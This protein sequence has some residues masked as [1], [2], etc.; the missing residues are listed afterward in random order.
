MR[1]PL[2]FLFSFLATLSAQAQSRSSVLAS[3][4]WLKIGVVQ[5]GLYRLDRA[6]LNRVAPT[7]AQ[8]DP[9]QL[10]LFGNGGAALPQPNAQ[11]RPNDLTENAI[12]VIG[13][14]D[15]RF[16]D[17]D[18]LQFY[19][20]ATAQI[21]Y[22][23]TA[24]RFTHTLN[25]YS[26]T[27]FYFLTIGPS[28]GL[29]IGSQSAGSAT[30]AAITTF[31]DYIFHESE[32]NKLTSLHSGRAWLG[33]F[34]GLDKQKTFSA[35]WPGV[36]SGS[37]LTII[38]GV[39]AGNTVPTSFSWTVNGQAAGSHSVSTISGYTYDYQA[40]K[41]QQ[42]SVVK[43]TSVASPIQVVATFDAKGSSSPQAYVDFWAIQGQR[44]LQLY[45]QPTAVWAWPG[46]GPPGRFTVR[47][48]PGALRV[49]DITNPLR[50]IGQ[51]TALSGT[52]AAW[53]GDPARQSFLL[54]STDQAQAPVSIIPIAN[55]NLH[56]AAT[57]NLLLIT[58]AAFLLQANRLAAFRRNHDSLTVLV[59]TT[60]QVYNEFGSGQPDVT[61]IRDA[62]RHFFWQQPGTLRY[63]LLFGDATYDYKNQDKFLTASAQANLI[64]VYES[65]ESFH[66]VLSYSSDDYVGFMQPWAGQWPEDASGDAL[67]DLG[68]GRLPVKSLDEA[69]TVVDKLLRYGNDPGTAGDWQTKVLLVA[70]DGDQNLHQDDA[71]KLGKLMETGTTGYRPQRAFLDDF[72]KVTTSNGQTAPAMNQ[73]IGRAVTD[74]RLIVNYTG[75]GDESGWSQEQI[76]TV[77]DI[78]GWKNTRLPLLVT[79][80]CQF[81]RYDDPTINSGAELAILSRTGGA[82]GLLTT[83]RP[84]YASSNFLLNQAFYNS[85]FA[86]INGQM[87]RLGDVMRITKNNSLSG[88][89]N[90]NFALLGDPSMRL[91]YPQTQVSITE[92]NGKPVNPAWP[93]TLRAMQS[94][95]VQG[96]VQMGNS[97][98]PLTNFSGT[99]AI[100]VYDKATQRTTLG[101]ASAPYSYSAF[102]SPLYAGQVPVTNGR[103]SLQF[104]LPRDINYSFGLGRLYAYALRADSLQSASGSYNQL[105][106]GGSGAGL[107]DTQPPSL[108]L[109][110]PD[111]MNSEIP[112]RVAGPN[113]TIRLKL[114]DD[115]GINVSRAGIGHELTM[116]LDNQ[117]P[118]I[119]N[120][121]YTSTS[122]DG[123]QGEVRYTFQGLMP[124]SYT[125]RA[126]GW[127]V[128]NNPAEGT[129]TFGVSA[130]PGLQIL[131][132]RNDPNP[133]QQQTTLNLTHNR[134]GDALTWTWTVLDLTGRSL[135]QQSDS[136]TDCPA[137]VS[138]GGWDG[139]AGNS[140]PLL[141]GLY[142]L[143][144]QV[145]SATDLSQATATRRTILTK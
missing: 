75:H 116:Q 29:R 55:Q 56:A 142:M 19:G 7:F 23:S 40:V 1:K 25:S 103:F 143:R 31:T 145:V 39:A 49:W 20:Q 95:R 63:L 61:A 90:R 50:P 140:Q 105:V 123:R 12:E 76:L 125:V 115:Y 42:T 67:L 52:D 74:G 45:G 118:V 22:D 87:P 77:A 37:S 60:E 112:L 119:L 86:P 121:L 113:V 13:E 134:P 133:F 64:P 34:F 124:G 48:A 107:A 38:T 110:L 33:E 127:D 46:A 129:L 57:P 54:F 84:V 73:L 139:T 18:A 8:A 32:Q 5:S 27:T 132:W 128:N 98:Q 59:V 35:D 28:N 88:S 102:D 24:R 99:V 47:S 17:G 136:C 106:I 36:V 44:G 4:S 9:R 120:D 15:G 94:V 66:P 131:D 135:A 138:I 72:H 68:V 58:P 96:M 71:N 89:L 11:S 144:L 14:S 70:D 101:M 62:A 69:R 130:K 104:V 80:T 51:A 85:V 93:D 117:L 78:L 53:A 114:A 21:A 16:D 108:T 82:I 97:G 141:P 126:R 92:V 122:I 3:G 81:G 10:R 100:T 41:N 137:T 91:A 83:T 79:A 30:G 111:A 26:D 43:P 109:N 2:L 65:R 6:T